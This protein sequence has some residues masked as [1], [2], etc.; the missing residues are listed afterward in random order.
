M[1]SDSYEASVQDSEPREFMLINHGTTNYRIAFGNRELVVGADIY[2]PIAAERSDQIVSGVGKHGDMQL[3][4]P[5]DHALVKRWL[6]L[7]VPPFPVTATL[8]RMQTDGSTEMQWTGELADLDWDDECTEARFR[9]P[10]L[11]TQTL[12]RRLPM[13]PA[14]RTCPHTLGDKFCRV[15]LDGSNPDAVPYRCTTNVISVDGRDVTIDLSNVPAGYTYRGSWL[16]K[17]VLEHVATGEKM[18]ITTQA[19]LAPGVGTTTKIKIHLPIPK[20]KNGDSVTVTVGCDW[21]NPT[22][23]SK[24]NNLKHNG[25]CTFMPYKNPHVPGFGAEDED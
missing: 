6:L 2:L 3:K 23:K 16:V 15:D 11:A 22:C 9:I 20:M 19:D 25:A 5:I 17:G 8:W 4:L 18:T 12:V 1:S 7:G 13:L 24:F 21:K 14:T 10:S